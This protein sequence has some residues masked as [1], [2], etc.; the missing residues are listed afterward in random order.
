[1]VENKTNRRTCMDTCMLP[2]CPMKIE[3]QAFYDIS[4]SRTTW[5]NLSDPSL[6]EQ[7]QLKRNSPHPSVLLEL[8]IKNL[9]PNPTSTTRFAYKYT[10]SLTM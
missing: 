4:S 5:K 1:M 7:T 6:I 2:M 9:M 10:C 3:W 8:L